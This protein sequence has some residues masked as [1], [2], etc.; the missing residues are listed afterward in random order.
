MRFC[1]RA[2]RREHVQQ[3]LARQQ[4][5]FAHK[6]DIRVVAHITARRAEVDDR[7]R[8]RTAFTV[9]VHM[10]HD[11]MADN[12]LMR[13]SGLVVDIRNMRLHLVDL[14]VGDGEPE[15]LF[16]F[17]KGDPE[18]APGRE[19][20]VIRKNGLHFLSRVAGA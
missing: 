8:L 20:A 12:V 10:R 16:A 6:D 7:H 3:H 13:G 11:V 14:F 4:Q 9:G 15:F 17:R 5:R 2:E 19:F 1:K 18:L